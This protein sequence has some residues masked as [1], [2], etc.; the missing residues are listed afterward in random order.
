MSINDYSLKIKSIVEALGSIKVTIDDDDLLVPAWMVLV[1]TNNSGP[2]S[3][4][5]K[6]SL[7]L[8]ILF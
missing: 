4:Q 5:G 2:P 7:V 6:T 3:T 1:N 8:Q